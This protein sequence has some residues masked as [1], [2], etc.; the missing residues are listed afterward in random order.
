MLPDN[1]NGRSPFAIADGLPHD[2]ADATTLALSMASGSRSAEGVV[3]AFLQRIAEHENRVHA[4]ASFSAAAVRGQIAPAV[5]SKGPLAG[6]PIG[7]KDMFDTVDHPTE[8]FSPLYRGH[9]PSADA[10]VVSLLRQA[11]AIIMGK[12]HTTEFAYMH[13]GPTRNPHDLRCTPGSSSAGSAAGVAAGFFPLALGTQTAG[14]LIKPAAFCGVYGFK[15]SFGLVSLDGVKPLAPTFDTVGWYGRSV[16]DLQRLGTVLVPNLPMAPR[17][18][19]RLRLGFCRTSR[20][21]SL[22]PEVREAMRRAMA[23]LVQ[24]GH[25]VSE[26][27]LPPRF[28]TLYADHAL[29]NDAEGARSLAAEYAAGAERLGTSTRAMIA[30]GRAISWAEES[31]ARARLGRLAPEMADLV[32]GYDAVLCPSCPTVALNGLGST[33]PSD[34]IKLWTAFGLPQVNLPLCRAEGTLP[35]GLQVIGGHRED[36]QVLAVAEAISPLV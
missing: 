30:R 17:L 28:D 13:T 25:R 20:W 14:S 22:T 9:Q 36:A 31:G 16:R 19:A 11:G 3:E 6:V 35:L 5:A 2:F 33:G 23:R 34:L 29:I 12:T 4:F 24:F 15:P 7:I 18:P 10:Q 1:N 27:A 26:V 8:Y 32:A 21:A